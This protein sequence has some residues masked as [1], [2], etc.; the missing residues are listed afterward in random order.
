MSAIQRGTDRGRRADPRGPDAD[1]ESHRN[2]PG[3]NDPGSNDPGSND[4]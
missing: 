4:D 3:S 2:D 1:A